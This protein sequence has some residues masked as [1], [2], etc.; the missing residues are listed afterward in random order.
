MIIPV[1]LT[2]DDGNLIEQTSGSGDYIIIGYVNQDLFADTSGELG[3]TFRGIIEQ[4]TPEQK[5]EVLRGLRLAKSIRGRLNRFELSG[6]PNNAYV[7]YNHSIFGGRFQ[8]QFTALG[9]IAGTYL[10]RGGT[11]FTKELVDAALVSGPFASFPNT[12][13]SLV[14]PGDVGLSVNAGGGTVEAFAWT[15]T[16]GTTTFS[17]TVQS[18]TVTLTQGTWTASVVVTIDGADYD[19]G[20]QSIDVAV[21]SAASMAPDVLTPA[22][23]DVVT[24]TLSGTQNVDLLESVDWSFSSAPTTLNVNTS[25]TDLSVRSSGFPTNVPLIENVDYEIVTTFSP[26]TSIAVRFL[27]G[28]EFHAQAVARHSDDSQAA[29][30]S[31]VDVTPTGNFGTLTDNHRLSTATADALYSGDAH[32]II[33]GDSLMN[34]GNPERLMYGLRNNWKPAR[35]VGLQHAGNSLG[36]GSGTSIVRSNDQGGPAASNNRDG[37]NNSGVANLT[38]TAV[39]QSRYV[40]LT[41]N[42]GEYSLDLGTLSNAVRLRVNSTI[43]PLAAIGRLQEGGDTFLDV[44]GARSQAILV[45]VDTGLSLSASS[46]PGTME[47]SS[48]IT[49]TEGETQIVSA[50]WNPTGSSNLDVLSFGWTGQTAGDKFGLLDAYTYNPNVSGLSVS[51][52]GDG[53]WNIANHVGPYAIDET[54]AINTGTHA[55]QGE[56]YDDDSIEQHLRM[57]AYKDYARTTLRDKIV[58]MIENQN[59]TSYGYT[60]AVRLALLALRTRWE[61]AAN[62]V[63]PSG[64]LWSRIQFVYVTLPELFWAE[65]HKNFAAQARDFIGVGGYDWCELI[66]LNQQLQEYAPGDGLDYTDPITYTDVYINGS[67]FREADLPNGQEWYGGGDGDMVHPEAPGS[68]VMMSEFWKIIEAAA[69]SSQL[70]GGTVTAE[71]TLSQFGE[72]IEF[73]VDGISGDTDRVI[74]WLDQNGT[75]VARGENPTLNNLP[76]TVTRVDA[77]IITA[78]GSD[79]TLVGPDIQINDLPVFTDDPQLNDYDDPIVEGATIPIRARATDAVGST[80]TYRYEINNQDFGEIGSFSPG[81]WAE[82]NVV[83]G[84]GEQTLVVFVTDGKTTQEVESAPFVFTPAS[85]N[86]A[87]TIS[88]DLVVTTTGGTN[89]GDSIPITCLVISDAEDPVTSLSCEFFYSTDGGSNYTSIASGINPIVTGAATTT[90][91]PAAAGDYDFRCIVTDSGGLTA[92]ADTV[93]STTITD[94]PTDPFGTADYVIEG[95]YAAASSNTT[96]WTVETDNIGLTN[97][98]IVNIWN[99]TNPNTTTGNARVRLYAPNNGD[100]TTMA[101]Y[102]AANPN[103]VFVFE[104]PNGDKCYY[105]YEAVKSTG[106][107]DFPNG[108]DVLKSMTGWFQEDGTPI[109]S[110]GPAGFVL[111]GGQTVKMSIY[112][113]NLTGSGWS[114]VGDIPFGTNNSNDNQAAASVSAFVSGLQSSGGSLIHFSTSPTTDRLFLN[115]TGGF[116]ELTAAT[117]LASR[118][119]DNKVQYRVV[120]GPGTWYE[121][122]GASPSGNQTTTSTN[123]DFSTW[124]DDTGK[125]IAASTVISAI[126]AFADVEIWRYD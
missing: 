119:T 36:G 95:P 107:L 63:D 117:E 93:A 45:G 71:P 39:A 124:L 114:K 94:V 11:A 90:F 25:N 101:N 2:D 92:T 49:L 41:L 59:G 5:A 85:A 98:V 104:V 69:S 51:Y 116:D 79:V 106:S 24:F 38:S 19:V 121:A 20:P 12:F 108:F 46:A 9:A 76:S 70:V 1:Y 8:S 122:M 72:A 118:I 15:I 18:P 86:T 17:P 53:G 80:L 40:P 29:A 109:D 32:M 87:P 56:W 88:L 35:W 16:D 120:T 111:G 22:L 62:A 102:L 10:R 23:G 105:I 52:M 77:R 47:S 7:K 100:R 96:N 110:T 81:T 44:D 125:Q 75:E 31:A 3:T 33:L 4:A 67:L 99:T 82:F 58:I 21:F 115:T 61:N 57:V 68:D 43:D 73:D 91:I 112:P 48:S 27:T 55:N 50:Q 26:A 60:N 42:R 113:T 37:S 74:V 89:V 84:V 54:G 103:A 83:A 78:D 6:T 97:K 126:A 123:I 65:S 14:L 30:F 13:P 28:G 34:Y 64:A 66:D